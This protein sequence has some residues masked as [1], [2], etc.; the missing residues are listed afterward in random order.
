MKRFTAV[1]AAAVIVGLAVG[2]AGCG[3]Y[4]F[5]SLRA[6]KAYLEA[7]DLY[8]AQDWRQA[9]ERY[10]VA[11]ANDPTLP[12][13][14]FFLGNSY[15][16]L[17]KPG[18]PDDP[19]NQAFIEKAIQNYQKSAESDTDPLMRQRA[20]EYLV[21]AY[22]P[23]KLNDPSQQ[24]PIVKRLIAASPNE[25]T[26]Y[27]ALSKIYQDAGRYEEA[28]QALLKAKE[29]KPN[30]PTVYTTLSQFYNSQGDFERTME[31]L[32]QAA[33]LTP[34]NPQG[35]HLVATYYEEKVRKDHRL[36]PAQ[37]KE[38]IQK[39][40]EAEDKALSLNPDYTDALIYKNILLRHQARLETDRDRQAALIKEA[41]QLRDKA[42]E[43]NRKKA[44]GQGTGS[45]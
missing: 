17:Y 21:A 4:S 45:R 5:S 20:M 22:G 28:E 1:S 3:K 8:R 43:L 15:D 6:R 14:H 12:G 36:P 13:V 30:D 25:P 34:D 11:A 2:A 27:F 24:E 38:Y 19:E 7:N 16:N 42:M 41:D 33:N 29:V 37:A 39:A 40:I 32:Q 35:F 44:T 23:D 9:A 10:E 31:P 26:N 18:R